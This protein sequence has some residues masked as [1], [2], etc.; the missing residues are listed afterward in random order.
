MIG[1]L[2]LIVL[3]CWLLNR[4]HRRQIRQAAHE[5]PDRDLERLVADLRAMT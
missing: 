5:L 4:N 1:L 3:V 2:T